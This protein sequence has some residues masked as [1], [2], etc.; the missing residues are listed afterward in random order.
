MDRISTIKAIDAYA[1][2]SGLMPTTI[3]QYAIKNRKFYE[4][5]KSG[6]FHEDRAQRVLAWISKQ[7]A[8]Q[9]EARP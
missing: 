2:A 9:P 8:S 4:R 5:M 1:K 6:Y 3:C 7:K